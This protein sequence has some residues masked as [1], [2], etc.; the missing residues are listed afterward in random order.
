MNPNPASLFLE[1]S[2]YFL[3]T[4]YRTKLRAAGTNPSA[5]HF[6]QVVDEHVMV[7][8]T[9]GRILHDAFKDFEDWAGL[10]AQSGLFENFA[11]DRRLQ[12]LTGFDQAA[13]KGP[14]ALQRIAP[15]LDQYDR[16]AP[17]N[18]R[19]DPQQGMPWVA[20]VILTS[21]SRLLTSGF[22]V[23][24]SGRRPSRRSAHGTPKCAR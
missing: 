20:A 12:T 17:E 8:W 2:R 4:E 14:I 19:A 21:D 11:C 15:A 16:A 22:F 9:P 18:Q 3:G 10:H 23:F 6:T 24:N 7:F 1:H 5:Y 13:G